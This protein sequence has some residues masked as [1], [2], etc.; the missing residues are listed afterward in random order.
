MA[1]V[2]QIM[3]GLLAKALVELV[4]VLQKKFN[5]ATASKARPLSPATQQQSVE[6]HTRH[7]NST[8]SHTAHR[9]W[10]MCEPPEDKTIRLPRRG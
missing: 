3:V 2:V 10:E 7:N 5:G 1:I 6:S 8:Q 4:I 9:S